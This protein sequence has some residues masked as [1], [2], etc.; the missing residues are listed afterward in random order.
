MADPVGE[1]YVRLRPSG[2]G[3]A[4]A[5]KKLLA[6]V[7]LPPQTGI[8][9]SLDGV[10]AQFKDV[11]AAAR[12]AA[13]TQVSE[14]IKV[15]NTL[16]AEATSY[17]AVASAA[18]AGS[19]EQLTATNLAIDA[20][21]RLQ[22]SLGQT[23]AEEK[24]AG[25][26]A[27]R[28]G[29]TGAAGAAAAGGGRSAATGAALGAIARGTAGATLGFVGIAGAITAATLAFKGIVVAGAQFEQ[30]L[31]V[32]QAVSGA[33]AK[34]MHQVGQEAKALGRDVRLPGV[35][36]ADAA[37]AMLELA[38]GGLTVTQS[39][40][41]AR[42]T[43]Q[44]AKAANVD[45][46]TA[47]QV[48]ARNLSAFELSG[49]QATKV[50]DLL[51]GASIA[52]TGE[53]SDMAIALQQSATVARNAGFSIDDTVTAIA[54]LA[55]AGL[56]GS[57][58]GTSLRTMILRLL[59]QTKKAAEK[60]SELGVKVLDLRG[61][62]LPLPQIL[63]SYR[64][65]LI[66]LSQAQRQQ[67]LNTIFGQD[68]IRSSAILARGGSAAFE[69]LAKT[70]T[71]VGQA[72]ILT[73]AQTKGLSGSFGA[74]QS[75]LETIGI[76]AAQ[77]INPSIKAIV[78]GLNEGLNWVQANWPRFE[79]AITPAIDR[80]VASVR[81]NWPQVRDT[82][83]Q[84]LTRVQEIVQSTVVIVTALWD[85]FGARIKEITHTSFQQSLVGIK[86]EFQTL[87]SIFDF[88]ADLLTGKWSD[89]WKDLKSIAVNGVKVLAAGIR[90]QDNV[91]Q[92]VGYALVDLMRDGFNAAFHALE[93]DALRAVAKLLDILNKIPTRFSVHGHGV[94]P[95][96]PA[97]AALSSV[98][99]LLSGLR[100]SRA[101][102]AAEKEARSVADAFA[103][104]TSAAL[105]ARSRDITD[106]VEFTVDTSAVR[107]TLGAHRSGK[108]IGEAVAAGVD[109]GI[110]TAATDSIR[111]LQK[112]LADAVV[113][114][115]QKIKQAVITAQQNLSSVGNN[116]AADL[117]RIVEE[118]PLGKTIRRLTDAL[119]G[120][121]AR[122]QSKQLR[123]AILDAQNALASAHGQRT[124]GLRPDS[125][126]TGLRATVA[127]AKADLKAAQA[128]VGN[129][130]SLSKSQQAEV[131][132]FLKPQ[133]DAYKQAQGALG[134]FI[135]EQNKTLKGARG[136]FSD[137]ATNTVVTALQAKVTGQKSAVQGRVNS[138]VDDFNRGAIDFGGF[139]K[140]I[141]ALVS[142]HSKD[143]SVAGR[144]LG[145]VF[146]HEFNEQ[147]A[148]L[149][150]QAKAIQA[151]RDKGLPGFL[152]GGAAVAITE[153][154]KVLNDQL[155][156]Q[157][158]I[159]D[160]L[161]RTR[162]RA[163]TAAEAKAAKAAEK[164]AK[165]AGGGINLS[166]L[167]T[168]STG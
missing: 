153:P 140:R 121:E 162:T 45:F 63:E 119:A 91:M 150:G 36:A 148:G 10:A 38:K 167:M 15:Q 71:K 70:V 166:D 65:A 86:A 96:N 142:G 61:N 111:N 155:K 165:K 55:K 124:P 138:I 92:N 29:V 16:R 22:R 154:V 77:R 126:A 133:L 46:G 104:N 26:A 144:K 2:D 141:S 11:T 42:G 62:L 27:A 137:F 48:T 108:K 80:V 118:G 106:A 161:R 125:Q 83:V 112:R 82:I 95:R 158:E 103:K 136:A 49:D 59:P 4:P 21:K 44:L 85:R 67:A 19:R 54:E 143:F 24:L 114:T 152:G 75:N 5:V 168:G 164:A 163:A 1:A 81:A 72:Q 123:Q 127:K 39:M 13:Q 18:T 109:T 90:S 107:S 50:A 98:R 132:K 130:G 14:S 134:N 58:A 7:R 41:A 34:Q 17:R 57:D 35:S 43:L 8:K 56:V 100:D 31:N 3:F 84:V 115:A 87:A 131:N 156:V 102:A 128:S 159:R 79:Q 97:G 101:K 157:R 147:I 32:F 78:D 135:R 33:T 9:T 151:G 66:P 74:L 149:L 110:S 73:E 76:S 28:R 117:E 53:V 89:V 88:F 99:E 145:V 146:A 113:D 25:A 129:V 64:K 52:A 139:S 51:A 40:E 12:A 60:M 94:G 6:S 23:A 68:A 30:Q 20:E 122:D 105:A 69:Q 37:A 93:E 160:E 120:R 47:A 116:L